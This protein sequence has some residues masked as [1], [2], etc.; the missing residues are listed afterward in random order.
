MKTAGKATENV[1]GNKNRYTREAN[2]KRIRNESSCLESETQI[3]GT[4]Q[5]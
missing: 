2:K 3:S 5:K 1:G 4:L